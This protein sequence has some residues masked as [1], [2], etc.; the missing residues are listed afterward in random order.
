MCE[1]LLSQTLGAASLTLFT[2]FKLASANKSQYQCKCEGFI[3]R[4]WLSL[5]IIV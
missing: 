2:K 5:N 1:Q 4:L 3:V